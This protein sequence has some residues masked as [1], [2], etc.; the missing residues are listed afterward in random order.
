[1]L[2][3]T[4][5]VLCFC[6]AL[7]MGIHFFNSSLKNPKTTIPDKIFGTKWS[8]PVKLDKQRN[9]WYVFLHVFQLLLEKSKFLKRDWALGYV[10]TQIWDFSNF[11]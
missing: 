5:I 10:P 9:V 4:Q 3:A 1:M 11:S 2:H 6:I 8:N 7:L